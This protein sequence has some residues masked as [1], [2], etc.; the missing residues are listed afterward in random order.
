MAAMTERLA[1]L[2][3]TCAGSEKPVFLSVEM[4]HDW[5]LMV[6]DELGFYTL[7]CLLPKERNLLFTVGPPNN[8]KTMFSQRKCSLL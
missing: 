1:K 7:T 4:I 8:E 3:V 2:R 5:Y 6:G